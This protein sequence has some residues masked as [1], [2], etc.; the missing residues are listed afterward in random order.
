MDRPTKS[1]S[2]TSLSSSINGLHT[3]SKTSA[4]SAPST[5]PSTSPTGQQASAIYSDKGNISLAPALAGGIGGGILFL[6]IF[7]LFLY[8]RRQ[9]QSRHHHTKV[10]PFAPTPDFSKEFPAPSTINSPGPPPYEN[11]NFPESP[12]DIRRSQVYEIGT[13]STRYPEEE[14]GHTQGLGIAGAG[15]SPDLQDGRKQMGGGGNRGSTMLY[16]G[17]Q[18]YT[19]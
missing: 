2:S 6:I 13:S 3:S 11:Q 5:S 12:N 16:T 8:H 10:I 17:W 1:A 14:V 18:T 9:K 15:S 7:L 4:P 19:P